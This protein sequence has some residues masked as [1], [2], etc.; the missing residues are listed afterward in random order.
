MD[1]ILKV[2]RALDCFLDSRISEAEEILAPQSKTSMYYSLGYGFILFLKC[3][4]TFEQA[5]V[6][7][8]MQALKHTIQLANAQRKRGGGWLDNITNWMKGN[9]IQHLKAMSRVH[10]HAELVYAEAYLLKALL[11]IV[12]DESI[13]AFLRE[14]LNIRNSYNTYRHLEKYVEFVREEAAAGKDTTCYQLDDHFTS[15]VALG[16]GCFNIVLSLLPTTVVKVAEFM[17]FSSDRNY[18]LEVL[19]SIGDWHDYHGPQRRST[20]PELQGPDEG[21]RRQLC[22]MVLLM[23]HIVLSKMIPLPNVDEV[24]AEQILDYNLTLYPSG[25][26]FLYF[27][28]RLLA[29]QSQIEKAKAQYIKAI[30]TQHDWKQLQHICY[31]E[32]GVISLIQ[33][34]WSRAFEIYDKLGKESNWSKAVY[35]YL[36]AVALYKLDSKDKRVHELMQGVTAAKQKIAGKSIPMEKFVS[37]K[38]RKF[39]EQKDYLILPDLEILN[40]F[41]AFDFMPVETLKDNFKRINQELESLDDD[42]NKS[43]EHSHYYD[44]LC[45]V[46]YLRAQVARMLLEKQENCDVEKLREIHRTSVNTVLENGS[47]IELDHYIYYFTR[48]EKARL[49]IVDNDYAGAEAEIQVILRAAEKGQYN[50]GSGPHAK[51]K[52]SLENALVFKCHNCDEKIQSLKK[53]AAASS[54]PAAAVDATD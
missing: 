35:M 46:N 42:H 31:W 29:S 44:D 5:D 48:Y 4:M 50:V 6:E 30:D 18:G 16:F 11:S 21:L 36:K 53:E 15:G 22:D 25:V 10:R 20:L 24:F 34:D 52:Y 27:S 12:Y 38:S 26:F 41:T 28:G 1:D 8:T 3:A 32:L 17:G 23:Y 33:Q 13:V 43:K 49:L 51:N 39:I 37:R 47:K 2:R 9:Q 14:G 45:T 40:A 7:K 19:E 54:S